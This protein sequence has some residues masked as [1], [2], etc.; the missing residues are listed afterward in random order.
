MSAT[1][2][3][4][5]AILLLLG[6]TLV[7]IAPA[8]GSTCEAFG[9]GYRDAES[10]TLS[11]GDYGSPR[12]YICTRSTWKEYDGSL[13]QLRPG[14]RCM[15]IADAAA[16]VLQMATG[17]VSEIGLY[18]SAAQGLGDLPTGAGRSDSSEARSVRSPVQYRWTAPLTQPGLAGSN[19][20]P[21]SPAA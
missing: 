10:F 21:K 14:G 13:C 16:S 12:V 18:L 2:H 9:R 6:V 15:A 1:S 11:G 20:S 7:E 5:A 8:A 3:G 4:G 19:S 17:R